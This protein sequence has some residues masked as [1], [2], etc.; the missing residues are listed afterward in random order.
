VELL[1]VISIIGVLMSLLLPAV[2]SA[3]EA[4]RRTQCS[5]NQKNL[6][7]ALITYEASH[8]QFPGFVN[9]VGPDFNGNGKRAS[10]LVTIF[11]LVEQNALWD[12]WST[13]DFSA[14]T[15]LEI[16]QVTPT[17]DVAVC[18]SNPSTG[19]VKAPMAYA[20]NAGLM[21]KESSDP[22]SD[23]N[24]ANGAFHN[25]FDYRNDGSLA[26]NLAEVA[27]TQMSMNYVTTFDGATNTL[28][29]S[30]NNQLRTWVL[31]PLDRGSTT[32]KQD[33]GICWFVR[34]S[35]Q[36]TLNDYAAMHSINRNK[37]VEDIYNLPAALQGNGVTATD[38][39]RP[40]SW[41][42]GGVNVAYGDGR[43]D[44]LN[45][46]IEYKVY[47]ELM[48]TKSSAATKTGDPIIDNYI[49]NQGEF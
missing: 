1:V 44:F 33:V 41:H 45:E 34:S 16:D 31:A 39:A 3:R 30:E 17:L 46:T 9:S 2:Q 18:P 43:V 20:V 7:L 28:L 26:S 13:K 24:P 47:R 35:P 19:I 10:W 48:T 25:H 4:G 14:F 32:R 42:P 29:L 6:A 5:N 22:H 38:F 37:E 11:P 12:A 40:S 21:N 49:L 8:K 15:Q 23:M 36:S 27:K